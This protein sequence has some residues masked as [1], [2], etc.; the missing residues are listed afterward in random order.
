ML[1]IIKKKKIDHDTYYKHTITVAIGDNND[2]SNRNDIIINNSAGVYVDENSMDV[3]IV[4]T[5]IITII[6]VKEK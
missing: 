4:I 1:K 2:P 5:I 6:I 3:I